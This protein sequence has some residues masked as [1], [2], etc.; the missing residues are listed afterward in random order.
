MI[1]IFHA[2]KNP[3]CNNNYFRKICNVMVKIF[4]HFYIL[5]NLMILNFV[6][7]FLIM[8]IMMFFPFIGFLLLITCPLVIIDSIY[9]G[10]FLKGNIGNL[11]FWNSILM[12]LIF[13]LILLILL[14]KQKGK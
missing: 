3:Y 5:I 4:I 2:I 13:Y 12:G 11:L 14:K 9:F 8:C 10:D 1:N 6:M 7:N